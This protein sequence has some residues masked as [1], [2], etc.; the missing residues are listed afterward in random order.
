MNT[1]LLQPEVRYTDYR[2]WVDEETGAWRGIRLSTNEE[3]DLNVFIGPEGSKIKTPSDI[4][5]DRALKEQRHNF[6]ERKEKLTRLGKF[7]FLAIENGFSEISA[8]TAARLVYLSTFLRYGTNNL[9]RTKRTR[10]KKKDLPEVMGM[11]ATT[12]FRFFKEVNPTYLQEDEEGYLSLSGQ[13]FRRGPLEKDN[14]SKAYQ[15]IYIDMVRKLYKGAPLSNHKELGYIFAM[16]PYINIEYNVLCKNPYEKDISEIK[17]MTVREFCE[18]IG[19]SYSTV[20][21]LLETYS[22]IC[23][24]VDSEVEQFCKFVSDGNDI[25]NAWIFVNPHVIY[26]GTDLEQVKVLGAFCQSP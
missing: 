21:R 5:A 17:M 14:E 4:E 20:S 22:K 24:L 1:N 23:F 2:I 10:M 11:S 9:Y 19:H 12:A 18:A 16:L 6:L 13:I 3:I 25:D 7:C 26:S 8:A 15:K